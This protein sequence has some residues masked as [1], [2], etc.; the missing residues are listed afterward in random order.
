MNIQFFGGCADGQFLYVFPVKDTYSVYN[1]RTKMIDWYQLVRNE[2]GTP[3]YYQ[4]IYSTA[5]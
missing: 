1:S 3:S 2:D 5:D 4:Y